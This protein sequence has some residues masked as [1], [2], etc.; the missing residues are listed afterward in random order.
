MDLVRVF[1]TRSITPKS[2]DRN[3]YKPKTKEELHSTLRCV[4]ANP[5]TGYVDFYK[6]LDMQR[7]QKYKYVT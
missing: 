3:N 5:H 4:N 7:N 6:N 1:L 2:K